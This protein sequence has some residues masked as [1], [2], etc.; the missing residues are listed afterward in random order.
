MRNFESPNFNPNPPAKKNE[1]KIAH[2]GK[3]VLRSVALFGTLAAGQEINP[4]LAQEPATK[5]VRTEQE[6][7]RLP[8]LYGPSELNIMLHTR[9]FV[10]GSGLYL[11][12]MKASLDLSQNNTAKE[13]RILAQGQRGLL[14]KILKKDSTPAD[15]D[16]IIEI[17]IYNGF[18]Q[19]NENARQPAA[20]D[21]NKK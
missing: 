11:A 1:N 7:S 4:A 5:A 13:V 2:L 17:R 18:I 14:I 12:H 10:E 9:V 8:I 20:G 3:K 21:N 19:P 6:S 15:K 16:G